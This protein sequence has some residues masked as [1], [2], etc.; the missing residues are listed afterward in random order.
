MDD[1]HF[2]T[3]EHYSVCGNLLAGPHG[4]IYRQ[5]RAYTFARKVLVALLI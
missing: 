3:T 4:D 2:G 5:K 1:G